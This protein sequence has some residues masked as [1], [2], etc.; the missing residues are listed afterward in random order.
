M[1]RGKFLVN[2]PACRQSQTSTYGIYETL[3]FAGWVSVLSLLCN[4]QRRNA[5][6]TQGRGIF[7]PS[8]TCTDNKVLL[9]FDLGASFF[10]LLLQGF[11]ISLGD[12]FLHRLRCAVNDVLSFLQA[13]A[14]SGTN[15]LNDFNLLVA[16]SSQDDGEFALLFSSST[17]S[18]GSA[19]GGDGH[20]GSRHTK[21]LFKCLN[22]LVQVENGQVTNGFQDI[23]LGNCHDCYSSK[24]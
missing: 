14:G 21:L 23:V 1:G 18:S 13:Q 6:S 9:D 16:G 7:C 10:Q 4:E 3:G 20:S 17:T 22:Q 19:R 12:A 11:S 8:P 2:H 5:K 15:H 24:F